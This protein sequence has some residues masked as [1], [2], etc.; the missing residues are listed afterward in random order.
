MAG[1]AALPFAPT[2]PIATDRLLLRPFEERDLDFFAR[3]YARE[4]MHRYLYSSVMDREAVG[5]WLRE[6]AGWTALTGPGSVLKLSAVLRSDPD[7]TAMAEI[8]LIWRDDEHAQGEIGYLIDPDLRG[9][10]YAVEAARAMLAL[11]FEHVG[12]HRIIAR[13]DT[14]NAASAAV[15]ERLGMRREADLVENE[16]V[17]GEWV[18]ET[19]YA[20]L[21][22]DWQ[23]ASE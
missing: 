12:F 4:D 19:I 16:F 11:G 10:G 9:H 3:V 18:S 6:R 15:A 21:A 23:R 22:D 14:R 2:F 1:P 8:T 20:M 17:K 13:L 5:A 7:S